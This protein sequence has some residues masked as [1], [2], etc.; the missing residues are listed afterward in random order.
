MPQLERGDI[1]AVAA[2]AR[3]VAGELKSWIARGYDVIA[4]VPSCALMLKFEWPL[5][6]PDDADVKL[7]SR[8]TYDCSEYIVD[9]AKKE[10]LAGG[11]TALQGG[12]TLH[13][14]CHARAQNMGQKA[15]EMLRLLPETKI[16]V[17][18]RC[19]GHGGSWGVEKG[20]FETAL[21]VGRPVAKQA[22]KNAM[23]FLASECPLAGMHIVQGIERLEG[24]A[25]DA[26]YAHHPI[27]LFARAYGIIAS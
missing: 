10:G 20:N 25:Q 8:A 13:M 2:A 27:E 21:K 1:A 12:I 23:Q 9:I 5:I 6:L 11:L 19:S 14:A 3:K 4:L 17:I 26:A 24:A 15:A 22:A 7:L 18:E 16:T